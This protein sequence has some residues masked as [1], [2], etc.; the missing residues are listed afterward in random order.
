M[1][2]HNQ[3]TTVVQGQGKTI[4]LIIA[5]MAGTLGLAQ[6]CSGKVCVLHFDGPGFAGLDPEHGPTTACQAIL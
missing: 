3:A 4:A 1:E 6:R 5:K 2:M